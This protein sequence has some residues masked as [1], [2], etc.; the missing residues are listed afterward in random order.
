MGCAHE[1]QDEILTKARERSA[2][3]LAWKGHRLGDVEAQRRRNDRDPPPQSMGEAALAASCLA[4][5][6][7]D[8]EA[9]RT[10]RA[11]AEERLGDR[12]FSSV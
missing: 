9:P 8:E 2:D 3:M 5:L 1:R 10:L 7:G 4:A 11:M 6:D 12:S